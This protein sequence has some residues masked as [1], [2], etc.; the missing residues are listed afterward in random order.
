MLESSIQ[1]KLQY[2]YVL[3]KLLGEPSVKDLVG[4]LIV[5]QKAAFHSRVK[6]SKY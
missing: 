3:K 4:G 2:E 1:V 5:Q 6:S